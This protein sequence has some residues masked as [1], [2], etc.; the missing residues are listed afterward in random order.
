MAS[1]LEKCRLKRFEEA[2][3]AQQTDFH[4]P[5]D[6]AERLMSLNEFKS[7]A[8]YKSNSQ[9]ICEEVHDSKQCASCEP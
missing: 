1:N 4:M 5:E 9:Q 2:F 7:M 3:R 8:V 6:E